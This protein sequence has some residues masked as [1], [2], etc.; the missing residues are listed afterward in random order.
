MSLTDKVIEELR[1][2]TYAGGLVDRDE[3]SELARE[4]SDL[5]ASADAPFGA[6]KMLAYAVAAEVAAFAVAKFGINY[7]LR[8]VDVAAV[9][10]FGMIF[11][12]LIGFFAAFATY[13]LYKEYIAPGIDIHAADDTI[14]GLADYNGSPSNV[15][16]YLISVAGGI[17]NVVLV[18][19][20][21]SI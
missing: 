8:W 12:F 11:V 18:I 13:K 5:T 20:L 1:N 17:A 19:V 14:F 9:A 2:D 15:T 3:A 4:F 21:L 16:I 6:Q 7:L 10:V